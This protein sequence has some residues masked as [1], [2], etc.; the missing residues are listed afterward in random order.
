M[1]A[2]ERSATTR[3]ATSAS[4]AIDAAK[5]LTRL[6]TASLVLQREILLLLPEVFERFKASCTVV[7]EL[8]VYCIALVQQRWASMPEQADA[9]HAAAVAGELTPHD[10]SR[11]PECFHD[12]LKHLASPISKTTGLPVHCTDYES[13]IDG[14]GAPRQFDFAT[15]RRKLGSI[16]KQKAPGLSGNGPD[17]Y[18]C[19]PNCW[20]EWAVALCN[21][22][23]HTQVTPRAWHVDLAHYV[24][25]GGSDIS[26]ANH[27]PLA[28][29]EVFRK[30][31]TSVVIGRMRRDWNRLQ[32]LDSCNPGFQAGR[33]T[34]NA[35]YSVRT[36][37]EHCVQSKTELA[38]LLDDLRWCFET[39][40]STV[41]E[42]AL[43][44]PGVPEFY[45]NFLNDIDLHSV[46]STITAAGITLEILL[47]MG[48]KGTH[49]QEHGTG[50]G[51][52]EGQTK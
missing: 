23:Q 46:K 41:I 26:L 10:I 4:R 14:D 30:V 16:A 37:T 21:I 6:M 50:Q 22:I 5:R 15:I 34:A 13:M 42:L 18:A 35:I 32:V 27:R 39:P 48:A 24:H 9:A 52:T 11:V 36:A 43:F 20:V 40:V 28:L 25:K 45:C 8:Y 12:L 44:R 2:S 29:I 31:F 7:Q 47:V 17:L 33:T 51:T 1:V 49:R 38:A 19:I 3:A